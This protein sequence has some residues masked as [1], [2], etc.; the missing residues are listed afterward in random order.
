MVSFFKKL[1]SVNR[2]ANVYEILRRYFAMNA[3]DGTITTL[4]VIM[5]AFIAGITEPKIVLVTAIS[6]SFALF[7]SG[8]WSAYLTE[9]AERKL[10]LRNLE[11]KLLC[12]LAKSRLGRFTKF[13]ALEAALVDGLSPFAMSLI[14]ITPFAMAYFS[15]L[16]VLEAFQ[17]SVAIALCLLGLLGAYLAV[18]SKQNVFTLGIRM[19]FAGLVAIVLAV[20][21][22]AI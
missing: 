8:F 2:N 4:G 10:A 11:K 3:F 20:L 17:Y 21:L 7:V 18:I 6:T 16:S 22:K 15:M 14:I 19:L 1:H 5:G 12:S 9:E 13:I